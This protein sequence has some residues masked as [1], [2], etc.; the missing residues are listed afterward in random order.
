MKLALRKGW[1]ADNTRPVESGREVLE[2]FVR[3][4]Q[5]FVSSLVDREANGARIMRPDGSQ[6]PRLLGYRKWLWDGEFTKSAQYGSALAH[7]YRIV[8]KSDT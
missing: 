2:K 8:L 6:V 4:R 1:G 7:R 3:D 5:Q